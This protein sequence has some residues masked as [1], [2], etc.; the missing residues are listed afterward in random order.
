[1]LRLIFPFPKR[2]LPFLMVD[3][4]IGYQALSHDRCNIFL[5]LNSYNWAN[6]TFLNSLRKNDVEA[7][8]EFM[9]KAM[10]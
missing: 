3:A 1:M 10:G 2:S 6:N 5:G 7:Q 9:F 4:I 8:V